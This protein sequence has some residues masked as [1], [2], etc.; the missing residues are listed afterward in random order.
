MMKLDHLNWKEHVMV[1]VLLAVGYAYTMVQKRFVP[2][3]FNRFVAFMVVCIVLA[4]IFMVLFSKRKNIADL[5]FF[6]G[7]YWMLLSA[8]II[9]VNDWIIMHNVSYSQGILLAIV[10]V[11]PSI[12]ALIY[13]LLHR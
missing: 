5:G 11:S 2:Q 3:D 6:L 4:F 8:I 7:V 12:S 13:K 10:F 9:I 1:F